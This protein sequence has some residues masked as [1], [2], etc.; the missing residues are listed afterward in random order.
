MEDF[1]E[2]LIRGSLNE[3]GYFLHIAAKGAQSVFEKSQVRGNIVLDFSHK[4]L[5]KV[6]VKDGDE[7][8]KQLPYG[9]KAAR[10]IVSS[11]L[12]AG[13]HK[14]WEKPVSLEEFK[15]YTSEAF[16]EYCSANNVDEETARKLKKLSISGREVGNSIRR[17]WFRSLYGVYDNKVRLKSSI[18]SVVSPKI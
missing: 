11:L 10:C 15:T 9:S 6:V 16:K 2:D 8:R 3:Y 17:G 7:K 5:L 4:Q 12:A 1:E 14:M 18:G 13:Y